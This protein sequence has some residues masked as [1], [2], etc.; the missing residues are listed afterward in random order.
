MG[1]FTTEE[2]KNKYY[3]T[4]IETLK[5][6]VEVYA[7]TE[8]EAMSKVEDA[9]QRCDIILDENDFTDVKFKVKKVVENDNSEVEEN[10]QK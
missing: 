5:K 7:D 6:R 2:N 4:V 10:L 9:Y 8:E 1:L 3:I